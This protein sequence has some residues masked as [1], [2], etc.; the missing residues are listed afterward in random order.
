MPS[1]T[2]AV[3]GGSR[4]SGSMAEEHQKT[5]D[6][7][8]NLATRSNGQEEMH[9]TRQILLQEWLFAADGPF[10]HY[11]ARRQR[12]GGTQRAREDNR[13]YCYSQTWLALL[14]F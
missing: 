8:R 7:A 4:Y 3:K 6:F 2:G 1:T 14:Q 9:K 11:N 12:V 5:I 10:T 13:P